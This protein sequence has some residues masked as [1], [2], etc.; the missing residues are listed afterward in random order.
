[1]SFRQV[2]LRALHQTNK[3]IVKRIKQHIWIHTAKVTNEYKWRLT[4]IPYQKCIN[5]AGDCYILLLGVGVD[6]TYSK[7]T[8][9]PFI[10]W[11][12]HSPLRPIKNSISSKAANV[13]KALKLRDGV[14]CVPAL[15]LFSS[16]WCSLR[17]NI[18]TRFWGPVW[19]WGNTW[20]ILSK[21]VS[22]GLEAR[23]SLEYCTLDFMIRK[24]EGLKEHNTMQA[25][26]STWMHGDLQSAMALP[27]MIYISTSSFK[28][29]IQHTWSHIQV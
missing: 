24:Q 7:I 4:R 9:C 22:Q 2:Q 6:P 12:K 14:R 15:G 10:F 18:T 1:M 11:D 21:F 29:R 27:M 17:K 20:N 8:I 5:P 3:T 13:G 25:S 23:F 28:P 26:C 16:F 19:G